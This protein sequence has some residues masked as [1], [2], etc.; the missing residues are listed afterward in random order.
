MLQVNALPRQFKIGVAVINDPAP[1]ASLDEVQRLLSQQ[2]PM[3]RHTTIYEEDGIVSQEGT[4][5]VYT[6]QL[7]PVKV[8]G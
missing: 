2:Y 3:L 5:V 4:A 8:K 6:F 7:V 1:T